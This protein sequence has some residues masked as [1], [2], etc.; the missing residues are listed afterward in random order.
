MATPLLRCNLSKY[1]DSFLVGSVAMLPN[2]FGIPLIPWIFVGCISGCPKSPTVTAFAPLAHCLWWLRCYW[3]VLGGYGWF[4][5][6]M[7]GS[8]RRWAALL[9][10]FACIWTT[11]FHTLYR[12]ALLLIIAFFFAFLAFVR[13]FPWGGCAAE[14]SS[15]LAVELI[16]QGHNTLVKHSVS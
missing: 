8:G 15:C 6:V 2:S 12:S 10:C 11:A 7:G 5:V 14:F 4:W 16:S 3:V 13:K 9:H 1:P